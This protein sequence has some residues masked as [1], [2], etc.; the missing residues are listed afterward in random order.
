MM[1]IR[2][3]FCAIALLAL[4]AC[5]QKGVDAPLISAADIPVPAAA[6][7][8]PVATPAAV[9]AR[10]GVARFIKL[11]ET[12]PA[13]LND[14]LDAATA[15]STAQGDVLGATCYPAIKVWVASLPPLPAGALVDR[16]NS[17]VP[18]PGLVTAFEYARVDRIAVE[19]SVNAWRNQVTTVLNSGPPPALELAC[20][21]LL[22]DER[23]F[24]LRIAALIGAGTAAVTIAPAVPGL[25]ELLPV[26]LSLP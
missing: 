7:P 26:P 15:Y 24:A 16:I 22:S 25:G 3:A 8:A 20:G 14:D 11:L 4:A 6:A 9:T 13:K 5:G 19:G 23:A 10:D 18:A 17:R 2:T 12:A 1:K 21:G